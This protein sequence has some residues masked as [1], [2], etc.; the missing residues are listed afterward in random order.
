MDSYS[1]SSSSSSYSLSSNNI[2]SHQEE[3][4]R[5]KYNSS[6]R[7]ALH[8]VRKLPMKPM[9]KPIAPF[10]PIPPKVYKVDPDNFK[11]VVQKLTSATEF[12]TTR[13]QEVA[14]PPLNLS[15]PWQQP[16]VHPDQVKTP[17]ASKFSDFM[18][19]THKE[20]AIK[21]SDHIFGALS[22]LGFNMSPSSLAWC[23]SVLF[24]PGTLSPLGSSAVL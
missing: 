19:E 16:L 20:K 21:P 5:G 9:K 14:P 7:S 22:P 1:Y 12:H 18:T 11:E 13:L 15:P 4:K 10:P 24:S 6:F 2:Y 3:E 17:P 8:S 23:S